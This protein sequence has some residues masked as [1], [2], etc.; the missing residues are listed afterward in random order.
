MI[1]TFAVLNS[2]DTKQP[3][4]IIKQPVI[5]QVKDR[6]EDK[7]TIKQ[8]FKEGSTKQEQ[9]E[10]II[11]DYNFPLVASNPLCTYRNAI[12]DLPNN[13]AI[14]NPM[15]INNENEKPIVKEPIVEPKIPQDLS[16][17]P[18]HVEE[19][20]EPVHTVLE[21]KMTKFPNVF[22]PN[23]DGNNDLYAIEIENKEMIKS[24]L[25]QIFNVENKIVF[26]SNNPDFEWNGEYNNTIKEGMYFCLVTIVDASGKV[27]KDKQ[28]IEARK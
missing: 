20:E 15:V 14:T 12:V 3:E 26:E 24:F 7:S 25:V 11:L 28:L 17:T 13:S 16:S 19:N 9:N 6:N 10:P 1:T 23:G 21:S 22:S 5:T 18:P 8:S 2:S 4:N 27:I